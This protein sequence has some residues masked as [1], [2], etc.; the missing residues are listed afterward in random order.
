MN[1]YRSPER[2]KS[3]YKLIGSC[4]AWSQDMYSFGE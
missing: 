1:D 3:D 2:Q 4:V